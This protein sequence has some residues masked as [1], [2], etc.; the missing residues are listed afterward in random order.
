MSENEYELVISR[1]TAEDT[2]FL[3]KATLLV[4]LYVERE[5]MCTKIIQ[6]QAERAHTGRGVWDAVLGENGM[7]VDGAMQCLEEVIRNCEAAH[8]HYHHFLVARTADGT[9]VASCSAYPYPD[10][11]ISK[12]Y[13]CLESVVL[14][15][16]GWSEEKYKQQLSKLDFLKEVFPDDLPWN[17][18]WFLETIFT[19]PDYRGRGLSGRLVKECLDEGRKRGM[20]RSLLIAAE[21]NSKALRVYLKQGYE[22]VGQAYAEEAVAVLGCR[23]FEIMKLEF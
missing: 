3:A 18:S 9:P 12:T 2:S 11:D 19:E 17:G 10:Y 15:I 16:L 5:F 6:V 20:A 14:N 13:K 23:G 4:M 7:I 1:A 8:I 21:G 22:V